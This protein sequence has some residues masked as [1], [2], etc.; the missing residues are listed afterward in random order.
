MIV[1]TISKYVKSV[2][3]FLSSDV[4]PHQFLAKIRQKKLLTTHSQII[5]KNSYP[6][7]PQSF[8]Q[9]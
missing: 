1:N 7:Y 4:Y 6:H 8:P 5:L 2:A 3:L 9:A